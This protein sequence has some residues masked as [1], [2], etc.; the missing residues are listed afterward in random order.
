MKVGV[1]KLTLHGCLRPFVGSI[2]FVSYYSY[3]K[4]PTH[5]FL[6]ASTQQKQTEIYVFTHATA[7]AA[8]ARM[9]VRIER[10]VRNT[11]S[12]SN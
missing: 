5:L 12:E 9:Q 11:P 6:R 7:G 10:A 4:N 1:R 2:L 8:A 3:F